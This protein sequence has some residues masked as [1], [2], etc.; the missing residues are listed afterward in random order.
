MSIVAFNFLIYIRKTVD[1]QAPVCQRKQGSIWQH[2]RKS[3]G[4]SIKIPVPPTTDI[5]VIKSHPRVS[6]GRVALQLH[7]MKFTKSTFAN[8]KVNPSPNP[9]A[10]NKE[11]YTFTKWME[12]KE[13][14]NQRG[15]KREWEG[16]ILFTY[17]PCRSYQNQMNIHKWS[18][19]DHF[20]Q[21]WRDSESCI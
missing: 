10:N 9:T 8:G 18:L 17:S 20:Q 4:A 21:V 15:K 6:N 14:E 13:R 3:L 11:T 2:T 5:L 1:V 7:R 16:R 19:N 12:E